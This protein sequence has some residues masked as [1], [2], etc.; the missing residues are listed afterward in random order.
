MYLRR[1]DKKQEE[2]VERQRDEV[3][4]YAKA[5]GYRIV[6]TYIDDGISGDDTENRPAFLRMREDAAG[7][8]FQAV[9]CWK[10]DRFGR[11]DMLDAG[12]WVYPFR[13][14]GVYLVTTDEGRI[15]W[16]AQTGQIVYSVT[17]SGKNAFLTDLS[18]NVAS[19]MLRAALRGDWLGEPPYGFRVDRNTHRLVPVP[20]EVEV[21][22]RIFELYVRGGKSARQVAREL[23]WEGVPTAHQTR[24]GKATQWSVSMIHRILRCEAYLGH[25]VW[26]KVT[27]AAYH[28]VVRGTAQKAKPPKLKDGAKWYK[29]RTDKADHVRNEDTH[30]AIIDKA[31]F[32]AAALMLHERRQEKSPKQGTV[33]VLTGLLRCGV[34]EKPMYGQLRW[35]R[36]VYR[37]PGCAKRFEH[38][39]RPGYSEIK[40][41][42]GTA[43]AVEEGRADACEVLYVCEGGLR[44]G[45]CRARTVVER[46][47]VDSLGTAVQAI[48]GNRDDSAERWRPEV[49]RILR[50][51]AKVDPARVKK[52]R[53]AL[54][55]LD[56]QIKQGADRYLT[57]PAS[58]TGE[59]AAAM[60]RLRAQ[61]EEEA[62]AL[63][64]DE[65]AAEAAG[66]VDEVAEHVVQ[67]MQSVWVCLMNGKPPDVRA[68]FKRMFKRVT[69]N[70]DPDAASPSV[71]KDYALEFK[72]DAFVVRNLLP[73]L[74]RVVPPPCPYPLPDGAAASV[75]NMS[76]PACRP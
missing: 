74:T 15:D 33:F 55:V 31:T 52:R 48:I 36:K 66:N 39:M 28:R 4:K 24:R 11:F 38:R 71:V 30:P 19:G 2:S 54:A 41:K 3:E 70:F 26:N 64:A 23:H 51:A 60:E 43:F 63:K 17:Q 21:V 1:S 6:T 62:D 34:C 10:T 12:Y 22:R 14:A 35:P 40:C 37:C 53:A 76:S 50:A 16:D 47:T 56:K 75:P 58:L 73:L 67:A 68:V 44:Y 7:G 61:R 42:C 69:V 72:P 9:L 29:E 5:N 20:E 27:S 8:T 32:A 49:T 25:T 45:T 57:A 46:E 65:E 59:I 18:K 13:K